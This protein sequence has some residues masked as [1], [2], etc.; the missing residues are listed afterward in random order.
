[1]NNIKSKDLAEVMLNVQQLNN[2]IQDSNN[3]FTFCT[4]NRFGHLKGENQQI[5]SV[6]CSQWEALFKQDTII[7][8]N[9]GIDGIM[10]LFIRQGGDSLTFNDKTKL[11]NKFTTNTIN[12]YFSHKEYTHQKN[13][14]KKNYIFSCVDLF[15]PADY[16]KNLTNLYPD[17]FEK[18]FTRYSKGESFF[19]KEQFQ[20]AS[21]DII[22][23][24]SQIEN[25]YMMGN[26]AHAYVDAKVLELLS[27][28]FQ[29]P[30]IKN[31]QFNYIK[32]FDKIKEAEY[33]LLSDIHNPPSIKQLVLEVGLNEFDLRCGFKKVFNNTIFGHLFDYK[34]QIAEQ[35][36]QDSSKSISEIAEQCGYDYASHFSTAFKRRFGISPQEMR[37]KQRTYF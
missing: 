31:S 28:Q 5:G 37:K 22:R 15:L 4:N 25:S 10:L 1:M 3:N 23:T 20:T 12:T 7:S 35:L 11:T 9:E 2:N 34:M 32:H 27:L 14:F 30:I 13:I 24:I 18:A 8:S 21:T 19:L 16:F 33:I 26:Y 29:P 36:L 6:T 17:L